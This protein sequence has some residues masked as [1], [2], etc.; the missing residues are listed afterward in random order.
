MQIDLAAFGEQRSLRFCL[1]FE[2]CIRLKNSFGWEK[3]EIRLDES[4]VESKELGTRS[5]KDW[6]YSGW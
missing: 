1:F 2:A 5:V 4:A 6:S 3:K